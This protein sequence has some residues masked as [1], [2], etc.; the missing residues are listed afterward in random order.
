MRDESRATPHS[1]QDDLR[2]I[3]RALVAAAAVLR[4]FRESIGTVTIKHGGD[5][6]T[7]AD[8]A[9]NRT[10]MQRLLGDDEGWLSEETADDAARLDRHRVWVVDPIDGTRE[11]IEG[12][13]EW[14]ISVALVEGT[15][16]VAGGILNPMVDQLV[17]GAVG[18][19][20]TVNG[21]P[22]ASSARGSLADAEVLASRSEVTR[23]QWEG[24][25]NRGYRVRP[26]GSVASKLS[27]VAAD[28][29]DATWTLVPK[30][31]WDVAAGVALVRAAGAEAF[32]PGDEPLLFNQPKTLLPGL[33]AHRPGLG[34]A[35]RDEIARVRALALGSARDVPR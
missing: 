14:C 20:V 26:M 19:G 24:F 6:V 27:L 21:H 11:F 9:V 35:V 17:L 16:A 23:G 18:M 2:R 15:D 22:V 12:I 13:P 32:C 31:E 28:Q 8:V 10:L 4:P 29:A 7:E 1:R 25:R 30:N 3:E 34:P 5:P 33:V